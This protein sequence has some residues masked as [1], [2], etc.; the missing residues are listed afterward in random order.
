VRSALALIAS[1]TLGAAAC[2]PSAEE[3]ERDRILRAVDALREAPAG[4]VEAR[5]LLLDEL[6]RQPAEASK[7]LLARDTCASAYRHMLDADAVTLD[8]QRVV[9]AGEAQRPDLPRRLDEAE[10]NVAQ[11]KLLMPACEAA[12]AA[13]R[14]PRRSP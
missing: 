1:V 7:A 9:E 12:L 13:L 3:V 2:G 14:H 10:A 6:E 11:A 5:R 8:I 4:A